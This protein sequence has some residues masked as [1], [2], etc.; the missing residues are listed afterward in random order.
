M[1]AHRD[2][3]KKNPELRKKHTRTE[4]KKQEARICRKNFSSV[5]KDIARI[6]SFEN[7]HIP[8]KLEKEE[9]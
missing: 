3:L 7:L 8:I 9:I 5:S 1:K 2:S 6:N 4:A